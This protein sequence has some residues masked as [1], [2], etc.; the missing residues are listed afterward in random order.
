MAVFI[1]IAVMDNSALKFFWPI[2]ELPQIVLCGRFYHQADDFRVKYTCDI[3]ALHIY[4]Y[5]GTIK[6]GS[7]QFN[8]KAGD[9]TITPMGQTSTYKF[10]QSG[11]HY[12]IHFKRHATQGESCPIDLHIPTRR[13]TPPADRQI[14]RAIQ[15]YNCPTGSIQRQINHSI[16]AAMLLE[17]LLTLQNRSAHNDN[18]EQSDNIERL[19]A[20]ID[21]RLGSNPTVP[22]LAE[23][24]GLSQNYLAAIFK[25]ST[26]TTI[27]QFILARKMARARYLLESTNLQIK[28]IAREVGIEDEQ[29]FN[30]KFRSVEGISPQKFRMRQ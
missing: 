29:Y 11:L 2:W 6:I 13:I 12:C 18:Q 14:K 9:I 4:D 17:A 23:T 5:D 25:K 21:S 15:I 10:A 26:G 24:V 7:Q 16:A 8:F 19:L 3:N 22:Q 1:N 28:A 30:K 27:K 20:V